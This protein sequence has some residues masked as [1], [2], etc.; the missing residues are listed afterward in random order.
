MQQARLNQAWNACGLLRLTLLVGLDRGVDDPQ[1]SSDPEIAVATDQPRLLLLRGGIGDTGL[2]EGHGRLRITGL[3]VEPR[4]KQPQIGRRSGLAGGQPYLLS[5][6]VILLRLEEIV[7]AEQ[8]MELPPVDVADPLLQQRD[9]SLGLVTEHAQNAVHHRI[10]RPEVRVDVR[11]QLAQSGRSGIAGLGRPRV[12]D[13]VDGT[14]PEQVRHKAI[15]AKREHAQ[16]LAVGQDPDITP[17][18]RLVD[19]SFQ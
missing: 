8:K 12:P 4:G 15:E 7:V 17:P 5:G 10:G 19:L 14:E 13:V 11:H 2:H 18:D 9:R 3:S 16:D 6:L 1:I